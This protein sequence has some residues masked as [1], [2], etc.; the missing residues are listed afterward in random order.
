[1]AAPLLPLPSSPRTGPSLNRLPTDH[2]I[3][4]IPL[5]LVVKPGCAVDESFSGA[6]Q[7]RQ[8]SAS[9]AM[10]LQRTFLLPGNATNVIT[11]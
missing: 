3:A 4:T 7:H 2:Q 11:Q 1:M 5:A 6:G 9:C 8:H 10:L